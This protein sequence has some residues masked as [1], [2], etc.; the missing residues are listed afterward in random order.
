MRFEINT[1]STLEIKKNILN[2]FN[3]H[4]Q[5]KYNQTESGGILLGRLIN[6]SKDVIVD[7]AS[8]PSKKDTRRRFFFFRKK[9]PAQSIVNKRW[10]DSEGTQIYLGEWHTHPECDP[11]PSSHDLENW[12]KIYREAKYEQDFLLFIIVGI[13]NISCWLFLKDKY[14]KLKRL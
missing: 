9:E 3:R 1:E 7:F 5:K 14:I 6:C 12:R 13:K 11:I 4:I 8:E 2:I 10:S